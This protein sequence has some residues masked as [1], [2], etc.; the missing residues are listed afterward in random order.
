MQKHGVPIGDNTIYKLHF[1]NDQLII[2]Q[3]F[4]DI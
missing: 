3:D 2:A 1:E 4:N